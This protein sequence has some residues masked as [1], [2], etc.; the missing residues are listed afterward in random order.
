M[1]FIEETVHFTRNVISDLTRSLEMKYAYSTKDP[2]L[3]AKT[4]ARIR[5]K[6]SYST[7]VVKQGD[8]FYEIVREQLMDRYKISYSKALQHIKDS[9]GNKIN[10]KNMSI[11]LPKQKFR[12]YVP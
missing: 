1:P 4:K 6:A 9:N 11:I 12:I 10:P 2:E 8:N 3:I 7:Y 5:I